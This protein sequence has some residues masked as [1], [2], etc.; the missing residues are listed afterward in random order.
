MPKKI[1]LDL[2]IGCLR[3]SFDWETVGSHLSTLR[4]SHL[5]TLYFRLH[6]GVN[7]SVFEHYSSPVEAYWWL[8]TKSQILTINSP[9]NPSCKTPTWPSRRINA[10]TWLSPLHSSAVIQTP[11]STNL[12]ITVLLQFKDFSCLKWMGLGLVMRIFVGRWTENTG[13][14]L[15]TPVII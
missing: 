12:E 5:H 8:R 14:L 7:W 4:M 3:S 9:S 2:S 11:C 6:M 15:L 13:N 1:T 10:W